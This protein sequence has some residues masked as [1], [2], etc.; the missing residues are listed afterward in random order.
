MSTVQKEK[1]EIYLLAC[2]YTHMDIVAYMCIGV[3]ILHLLVSVCLCWCMKAYLAASERMN[4]RVHMGGQQA[5]VWAFFCVYANHV[6][7]CVCVC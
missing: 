1:P 5:E 2:K 7:M 3:S 4:E 6:C